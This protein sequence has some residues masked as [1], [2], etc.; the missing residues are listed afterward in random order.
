MTLTPTAS[1]A[2]ACELVRATDLPEAFERRLAMGGEVIPISTSN[3]L[4]DTNHTIN[5]K[6]TGLTQNLGQL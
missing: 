6:F 3:V 2:V 1:A 5:L 4:K